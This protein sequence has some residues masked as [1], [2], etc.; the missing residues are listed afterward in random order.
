MSITSVPGIGFPLGSFLAKAPHEI[1]QGAARYIQDMWVHRSGEIRQR[2]PIEQSS[3][4]AATFSHMG[5]GIASTFDPVS[6]PRVAVLN[7]DSNPFP[8]PYQPYFSVLSTDFT[9]KT[10]IPWD[11]PTTLLAA[12]DVEGIPLQVCVTPRLGGGVLI[13]VSIGIDVGNTH[14][15]YHWWG[16]D[17]PDYSTGTI[18]LSFGPFVTGSGTAWNANAAAGMFLMCGDIFVGV[19]ETVVSD[20]QINLK[21]PGPFHQAGAGTSYRL[22]SIRHFENVAHSTGFITTSTSSTTVT[23]AGTKFFDANIQ[24][25]W[26]VYR[27]S[28]MA[29]IGVVSSVTDN[30]TLTLTANAV[31]ALTDDEFMM[32]S[33]TAGADFNAQDALSWIT[34]TYAG[35]Q[36]YGKG[37]TLRFSSD[38]EASSVDL[39]AVTGDFIEIPSTSTAQNSI[40]ALGTTNSSL[41][42]LKETEAWAVFGSV[43][44]Q[45]ELRKIDDDGTFCPS[46]VQHWHGNVIYAGHRGIHMYD[47]TTT[48]NLTE[49]N[50]GNFYRDLMRGFNPFVDAMWSALLEDIYIVHVTSSSPSYKPI[51]G[52]TT[53]TVDSMTIALHLPTG[54]VTF[55]TNFPLRGSVALPPSGDRPSMWYVVND[56]NAVALVGD[57]NTLLNGTGLDVDNLFG[58][59]SNNPGPLSY[60]EGPRLDGGDPMLKKTWKRLALQYDVAADG[61]DMDIVLGLNETGVTS[62]TPFPVNIANTIEPK[63]L[64]FRK[65]SQFFGFR[66]YP[67]GTGNRANYLRIGPWDVGYWP[68]RPGHI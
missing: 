17:K 33:G 60:I 10:D 3:E 63:Q 18:D 54:A 37:T 67:A 16:G 31:F 2:G 43:P 39:S 55:L 38:L 51:R 9:T 25:G 57:G 59:T 22:T 35:R 5:F 46:A 34:G 11:I 29:K 32:F 20:T 50:L 58:E 7:M 68:L 12:E 45:F 6:T 19:V 15:L 1:P 44:E 65:Q 62:I 61:I 48:T 36:W 66:L 27:A 30:T 64:R 47:G 4:I 28:D 26:F 52:S 56:P 42:V 41:L 21:Y 49:E 23:G 8:T 14:D 40:A 53:Q 13:G 24:P